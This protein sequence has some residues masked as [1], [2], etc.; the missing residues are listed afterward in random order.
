MTEPDSRKADLGSEAV[1]GGELS[2][3]QDVTDLDPDE[4]LTDPTDDFAPDD[5]PDPDV[6]EPAPGDDSFVEPAAVPEG[7]VTP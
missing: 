4:A 1:G 5:E 2:V 6:A 7:T 3:D